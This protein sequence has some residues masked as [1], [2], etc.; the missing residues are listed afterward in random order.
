MMAYGSAIL[1]EKLENKTR[2]PFFQPEEL[3]LL[4]A[5]IQL[6]DIGM[7]T[8]W[9][10]YLQVDHSRGELPKGERLRI[11]LAHAETTAFVIRSFQRGL[12]GWLDQNLTAR[13]KAILCTDLNE[14]LAFVCLCHNR[15][16]LD[17]YLRKHRDQTAAFPAKTPLIA[18][19]LQLC[20]TLHMDVSRLNEPRFQDET[21]KW[22]AG[23]A[24]EADYEDGDWKRFFQCYYVESVTVEPFAERTY[25]LRVGVRFNSGETE[26]VR[27]RF[28]QIYEKRLQKT[29]H[30][31]LTVINRE[32]DIHF[33]SDYVFDV[34]PGRSGKI[35]IPE[36]LLHLFNQEPPPG[37][38]TKP[39]SGGRRQWDGQ[40]KEAIG[41]NESHTG[42][43]GQG[44]S[45][46]KR[47]W[48]AWFV[49]AVLLGLFL[50]LGYFLFQF[51][52][53]GVAL[54]GLALY[55]SS[56]GKPMAGVQVT[57]AGAKSNSVVTNS[58][59]FFQLKI[60]DKDPGDMVW[61]VLEKKGLEVLNR[62]SLEVVLRKNPDHL[63]KII[64]CDV[65]ERDEKAARFYDIAR[66]SIDTSYKK[67]LSKINAMEITLLEKNKKIREI[68]AQRDA[69]LARAKDQAEKMAQVDM[70]DVSD[71]YREAV[72]YYLKKDM[73]KAWETLN[74]DQIEA[75]VRDSRKKLETCSEN[76]LLK[77]QIAVITLRF[78]EAETYYA[79]ALDADPGNLRIIDEYGGYLFDQNQFAK[80]L[81]VFEKGLKLAESESDKAT[82]LLCI[83]AQRYKLNLLAES[84]TVYDE[85]LQI[86]RN[87]AKVNP[88]T[89]LPDVA[90]TLN[91]LGLFYS[92]TNRLSEARAAYNEALSIKEKLAQANPQ[93]FE[94]DLCR[95]LIAMGLHY[96][97]PK[98]ENAGPDTVKMART[99][100]ERALAIAQKY[101]QVHWAQQIVSFISAKLQQL[102]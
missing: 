94:L 1:K 70:G 79:K 58:S 35:K 33:V 40:R 47:V 74:D 19:I 57:V 14:P 76:Y 96:L 82:F 7:Q 86:Y 53:G 32:A 15:P 45:G 98:L 60:L 87:L 64:L 36:K 21:Q 68:E 78:K 67:L 72:G 66:E 93:R 16:D 81:E 13:E 22:L 12:P 90:N 48:V 31:C 61:L 97:N 49:A 84:L 85:A 73:A 9:K 2:G 63:V 39:I 42:E 41:E 80:A 4:A 91:N 89:Y 62:D 34:L 83:G 59:G 69:A 95:T 99:Y 55:Q 23:G 101:P 6:H 25:R 24:M 3:F 50:A 88:Q 54:R 18:A 102:K 17:A 43:K 71:M 46:K 51:F 11:R 75:C 100:L 27:K 65:G 92:A 37:K 44:R 30:D 28:L 29:R 52:S 26:A 10:E 38:R 77:A 5:S 20:D 8:G 56:I